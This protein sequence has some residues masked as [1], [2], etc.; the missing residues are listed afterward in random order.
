M[1]IRSLAIGLL[2]LLVVGCSRNEIQQP[3]SSVDAQIPPQNSQIEGV[4][5]PT[6]EPPNDVVRDLIFEEYR[7]IEDA[8]GIPATVTASGKGIQLR[9]KLFDANKQKCKRTPQSPPGWY[10]CDLLI[11]VSMTGDGSDPA[12]EEPSEQGARI[13]VKWD[14][15]GKWVRQ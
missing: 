3:T 11:K 5:V 12:N 15:S 7:Q 4:A 6:E 9:A 2:T 10:E 14:P 8:G 13:G 1:Y